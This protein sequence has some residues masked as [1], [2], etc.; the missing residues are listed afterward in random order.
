MGRHLFDV[1]EGA[2]PVDPTRAR[3]TVNLLN[4]SSMSRADELE[5]Q[6]LLKALG[7]EV[8]IFPVFSKPEEMY[9]VTQA[10][11]SISVCPTHDDYLLTHLEEKY[12]IPYV[13]R[14]MPIGISNTGL[15][16]RDIAGHL[17]LEHEAD[18]LIAREEAELAEALK[19]LVHAFR[20]KRVFLSAGEYRTLATAHL[21]QELGFKIAAVRPF[22]YDEFA[23][24][25]SAKLLE[26]AARAS[27]E[28]DFTL[29]VANCQPFEEAN[30]IRKLK[31][32][33]FLGHLNCNSTAAK[34]GIP[35]HT[36]Y[37]TGLN[38]LGYK[39]AFKLARRLYR[40]L[41]NPAFNRRLSEHV[42]LPYRTEWYEADPFHYINQPAP[43]KPVD[44]SRIRKIGDVDD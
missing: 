5:L 42:K 29:N 15:W 23:E 11:L 27:G 3:H 37:H 16:L 39:G 18:T 2:P 34:L 9:K 14:D 31:P 33:L 44:V 28:A 6:R 4:V 36:I 43:L 13:L 22:H 24:H 21:L 26:Q 30:L 17:G 41:R 38:Y 19:T 8:N 35:T 32:D 1:P 7:L 10:G 12:G 20:G 40:Q 25:E